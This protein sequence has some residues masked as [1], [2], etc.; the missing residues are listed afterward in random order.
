MEFSERTGSEMDLMV[1][2]SIVTATYK[3]KVASPND[4]DLFNLTGF[5]P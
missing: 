5:A 2:G 3:T 4:Q 1:N